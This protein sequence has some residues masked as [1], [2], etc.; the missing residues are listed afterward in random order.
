ML[1]EWFTTN[2]I[3]VAARDLTYCD[4]PT[5]YTWDAKNKKKRKQREHGM[6]IGRFYYVNPMKGERF[7]LQMLLIIVKGAQSY[8]DIKAY[9]GIIYNTFK[10]ACAARGL[11]NNDNEWY[12]TFS[13]AASWVTSY[14]LR[15]LFIT[16]LLFCGIQNEQVFFEKK[17]ETNGR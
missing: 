4:F 8:D 15:Q 7:Y 3:C 9:K 12:W 14:Q 10:E 5:K 6:K 16:M 11:L 1:T 13:E 17:L 2:K